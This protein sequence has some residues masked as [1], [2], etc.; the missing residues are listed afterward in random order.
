MITM[1]STMDEEKKVGLD[2]GD[3]KRLRLCRLHAEKLHER[4]CEL[5]YEPGV[6]SEIQVACLEESRNAILALAKLRH[7]MCLM[8]ISGA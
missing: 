8:R 2:E 1:T 7:D 3:F 5:V 4:L 6:T